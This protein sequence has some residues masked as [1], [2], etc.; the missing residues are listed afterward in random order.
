MELCGN[1]SKV[2]EAETTCAACT[3]PSTRAQSASIQKQG[4]SFG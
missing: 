2:M 3:V 4:K 1:S